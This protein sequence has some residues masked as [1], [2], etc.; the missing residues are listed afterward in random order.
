MDYYSIVIMVQ[1][2][3]QGFVYESTYYIYDINGSSDPISN[4]VIDRP[5]IRNS[6]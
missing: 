2:R 3:K 5:F 1:N 6:S 4:C